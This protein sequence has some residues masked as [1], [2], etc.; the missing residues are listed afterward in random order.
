MAQ[1]DYC[2]P[3]IY[4][5]KVLVVY[6]Q[7]PNPAGTH[8]QE[9][10]CHGCFPWHLEPHFWQPVCTN[11]GV[12]TKK[13]N[14]IF[15]WLSLSLKIQCWNPDPHCRVRSPTWN[16]LRSSFPSEA[17]HS[18]VWNAF[19]MKWFLSQSENAVS[20]GKTSKRYCY[21][22]GSSFLSTEIYFHRR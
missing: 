4:C 13:K 11:T 1:S 12:K 17:N 22:H 7:I 2:F 19:M 18:W 9:G 3:G 6:S 8:W 21:Q 14:K 15:Q 10:L 20:G 16:I 5:C